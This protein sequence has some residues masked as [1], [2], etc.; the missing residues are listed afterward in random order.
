VGRD[1]GAALN[2]TALLIGDE[3]AFDRDLH[4]YLDTDRTRR[5]SVTQALTISGLVDYSMVPEPVMRIAQQRGLMVHQAT[6]VIDRGEDL[7]DYEIPETLEGYIDGYAAFLREMKFIPDREWIEKPMIVELFGHRVGM[8]PDAVGTINGIP[9]LIER[10]TCSTAHPAWA[11]QT[12]GYELG[13]K[14]AGLQIRQRFAVRL[15]KTGYYKLH[16]YDDRGDFDTFG[17]CYRLAAWKLKHR[18]AELV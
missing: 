16:P 10:K 5:M 14:A 3:V 7:S 12:A 9:T 17:D 15:L 2:D 1:G 4:A 6:A 13:L 18:L 8:T 11:I